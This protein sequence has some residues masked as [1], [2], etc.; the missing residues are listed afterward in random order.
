MLP[1]GWAEVTL[2]DI[3]EPIQTDDPT[4]E[5]N[6]KFLYVDI[7]SIDNQGHQ[8]VEPKALFGRDAPSRARR[9]VRAGDILFSTVRPHLK[10]IAIVPASL[11]G[12]MTS[13][14]ICVLRPSQD[15]Q[16]G[17]IFR[18][19]VSQSFIDAMTLA[20]DGTMYPAIADS[21]VFAAK[22]ALPPAA[23]QR[24]IVAKLDALTARLT[25]ARAELDR[26][27]TLGGRLRATAI[28]SIFSKEKL[29]DWA[30]LRFDDVIDEGL[31]GLIRSKLEQSLEGVPYIRMNHFNMRGLWNE[32]AL[33]CVQ[34]SPD[35]L[36]RFELKAGDVLFNTRNSVELVGKVAMWP[37]GKP[38]LVYNNNLL[39]LRFKPQIIPEFAFWYMMSPY[40]RT[41]M[42]TEK[43][44]TTS[45]AA[46]YQRS[47]N[48]API[49]VPSLSEQSSISLYLHSAFARAD[50]LEA[51]VARSK[52]L[53]DRLETVILAKAFKGELVPQDPND[54][55]A[56][57][58]LDRIRTQR[59][60]T[61]AAKSVHSGKAAKPH[62]PR[63]QPKTS[64]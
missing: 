7:G 40:F 54:E 32:D 19:V 27:I 45:V 29:E 41:L 33:T 11:D 10:N 31:I 9:R 30:I 26:V 15:V 23:E 47:L 18:R 24:R 51:E 55:P 17:F 36:T 1:Q 57:K 59:V 34:I 35:E 53:L 61:A 50:R 12:E 20:S 3:L 46:I 16:S 52:K 8:I 4:K 58:L 63:G 22:I 49:P 44:A 25:R 48:R 43:S 62:P 42:E 38:G 28:S 21:D 39:R 60:A 64:V 14:G 2:G 56:S 37:I 5:P 6:K 13:T